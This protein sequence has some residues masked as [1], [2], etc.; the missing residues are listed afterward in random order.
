MTKWKSFFIGGQKWAVY[1]V[2][3]KSK[4]LQKTELA[5]LCDVEKCKIYI[6]R[7]LD[8]Q[9]REDTL[10]HEILHALLYV[11]GCG[12]VFEGTPDSE[13]AEEDFVLSM[14]PVL[15]RLLKDLGFKFP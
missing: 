5:G 6:S 9:A 12:K 10:L 7:D 3:A 1:I 2:S 8:A 15:H 14:T 11:T 4:F 13:K